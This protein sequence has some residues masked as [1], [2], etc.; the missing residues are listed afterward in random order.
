MISR[1]AAP[2][3]A[4]TT[5]RVWISGAVQRHFLHIQLISAVTLK[6]THTALRNYLLPFRQPESQT[7]PVS[8][9]HN[10]VQGTG[11]IL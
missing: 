4:V 8:G 1:T 3:S 2:V 5:P 10:A 6:Y 11:R 9:E 7:S